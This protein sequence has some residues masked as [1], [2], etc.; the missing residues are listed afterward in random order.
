MERPAAPDLTVIPVD[1]D[2]APLPG[3]QVAPTSQRLLLPF[4][5]LAVIG[6]L[7][8]AVVAVAA[9]VVAAQA[10]QQTNILRHQQ[11]IQNAGAMSNFGQSQRAYA[12]AL[13]KCFPNPA[14]VMAIV[15]PVGVP[16]V[17]T[18]SLAQAESDL[19]K[20][21]LRGVLKYG[22]AR[23]GSFVMEQ[24]PGAG[25][26]VPPGTVVELGTRAA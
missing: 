3:A 26:T 24:E 15:P 9:V 11:C 5:A 21:G 25:V 17:V 4:A 19:K 16:G 18:E 12:V 7:A 23:P 22:P 14:A 2:A 8:L 13:S 20:A 1:G 6:T 10:R